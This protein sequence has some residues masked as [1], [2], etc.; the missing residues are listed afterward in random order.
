MPLPGDIG[1]VSN[2]SWVSRAIQ[3]ITRAPVSH[4]FIYAGGGH[5][6]EGWSSGLRWNDV[7]SYPGVQWLTNLSAGL[8]GAQ[9][10]GVVQWMRAHLGTPYSWID[11]AEIG[12]TDLF[13]WAPKWMRDRLRS[14]ATLMCSQAVVGAYRSVG[15]DLFPGRPEGGISPG[16]LWRLSKERA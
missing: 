6:L 4:A 13:H 16:D 10:D 1:V 12:F 2:H 15:V 5:L 14:D 3:A 9:R 7:S 11:D 8:T